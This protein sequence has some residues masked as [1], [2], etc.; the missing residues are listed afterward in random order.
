[1]V[2]IQLKIF[3]PVGTAMSI[4]AWRRRGRR[5][6]EP[7]REHVVRPDAEAQDRDGDRRAGDELVAEDRLAREDRDDLGDHPERGQRHDVDL[8]VTEGPEEVLPQKGRRPAAGGLEEVRVE[9]AIDEQHHERRVEDGE[10]EDDEDGVDERH[11]HEERQAA[12]R[13]ARRAQREDRRD[14]VDRAAHRA[15]AEHEERERPSSRSRASS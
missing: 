9:L 2:A 8:G 14:D 10:R 11:P 6:T 1:M 13:Q 15:D 7:H 3:T 5:T 4:P 12:H